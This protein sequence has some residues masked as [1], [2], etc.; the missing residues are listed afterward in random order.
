MKTWLAKYFIE[1]KTWPKPIIILTV[2]QI[3]SYQ[4]IKFSKDF[5]LLEGHMRLAYMRAQYRNKIENI[6]KSHLTWVVKIV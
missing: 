4:N 1:N 3:Q 6:P 5:H 2:N